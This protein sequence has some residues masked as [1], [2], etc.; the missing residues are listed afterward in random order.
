MRIGTTIAM[1]AFVGAFV[2]CD[3]NRDL[4]GTPRTSAPMNVPPAT[5]PQPGPAQSQQPVQTTNPHAVAPDN[6]GVAP[7]NQGIAPDNQ[8]VA[9][10]KQGIAPSKQGVAPEH[11]AAAPVN[12][13]PNAPSGTAKPAA[14]KEPKDPH[15]TAPATQRGTKPI[16]ADKGAPPKGS[17]QMQ[18]G[19]TATPPPKPYPCAGN[20]VS[21]RTAGGNFCATV[22]RN[23]GDC[24]KGAGTCSASGTSVDRD[25][26]VAAGSMYCSNT[27]IKKK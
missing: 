26:L 20:Q 12:K 22:C 6:Q 2:G 14:P 13:E 23:D 21:F 24:P 11:H 7:D 16:G 9:P 18:A 5:N 27:S 25:G 19:A 10:D 4:E 1:V 15:A 8:G 17:P 3:R